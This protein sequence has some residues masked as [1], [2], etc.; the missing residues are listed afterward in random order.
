MNKNSEQKNDGTELWQEQPYVSRFT[1]ETLKELAEPDL[2]A[3]VATKSF[4]TVFVGLLISTIASYLAFPYFDA[5]YAVFPIFFGAQFLFMLINGWVI[6][7]DNLVFAGIVYLAFS[8]NNGITFCLVFQMFGLN[9]ITE[10]F[11]MSA[12][13]FGVMTAIGYFTKKDLSTVG[14]VYGTVAV[15]GVLV[16][17][18]NFLVFH[19]SG[20]PMFMNYVIVLLFVG[21][22]AYNMTG[23]RKMVLE[24][25]EEN[26]DRIALFMGMQL[27]VNFMNVFVWVINILSKLLGD[28][29][30]K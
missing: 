14:G 15:G 21:I 27:Y 16:T 3:R 9:V 8:V 30:K 18:F 22:I 1:P 26:A 17:L 4:A 13:V 29:K 12:V 19:R 20:F 11:L 5:L 24:G 23:W 7:R 25:G 6:G 10:A 28:S 2:K